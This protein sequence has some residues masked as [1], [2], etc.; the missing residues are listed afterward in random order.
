MV[1]HALA[2]AETA[3]RASADATARLAGGDLATTIA[4][5]G[6]GDFLNRALAAL[7]GSV[8]EVLGDARGAARALTGGSARI[9]ANAGRLSGAAST[10]AADLAAASAS[11][12]RLERATVDAGAASID[13]TSAVSSVGEAADLLDET[14]RETAA[15]LEELAGTVEQHAEIALAIR[16]IARNATTVAAGASQ[17][18]VA[19]TGAGDTAVGALGTT[20]EGIETLHTASERIGD[21]TRTIDEI[22]DQTNLL[23]LNAAIE[24]ARAGEHGRGFAVVADEIRKLADRSGAAT[25]EIGE[26]IREVQARTGAAVTAAREGDAAARTARASTA[27]AAQALDA[28][29]GDVNE[30]ARRLEDVGRAHEEQ[31]VTTGQLVRATGAV[32]DQAARN[33]N[34]ASGLG[35]LAEQL[36]A[37]AAQGA[38]AADEARERVATAVRAGADVASEAA[39][40][41]ELTTG[42]RAASGRLDEAIARFRDDAPPVADE[43]RLPHDERLALR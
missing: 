10:I 14:V 43:S 9:D 35:T 20:R 12:E 37:I 1:L 18:L 17:A 38:Q 11:V 4:P 21:I 2:G 6:A 28:I 23:A 8:R 27:T 3:L 26:V 24:A 32:R 39:G 40:L 5:R 15:A 22:A 42:L 34:V 16:A 36:A 33:R 29:L 13:L 31:R 30:V 41:G 25:R 19:A 7:L